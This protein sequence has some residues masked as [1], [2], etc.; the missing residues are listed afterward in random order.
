MRASLYCLIFSLFFL[1]SCSQQTDKSNSTPPINPYE[2]ALPHGSSPPAEGLSIEDQ[3]K[4]KTG[5]GKQVD[6]LSVE[7]LVWMLDSLGGQLNVLNFW[8][9][10]CKECPANNKTL[11]KAQMTLGD[12]SVF[13]QHINL[14][15][16]EMVSDV[17][18]Q[19]RAQGLINPCVLLQTQGNTQ[20][21]NAVQSN[22]DGSLPALVLINQDEGIR[23]FY[24]KIFSEDELLALFQPFTL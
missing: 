10:S 21:M 18:A 5:Y 13:I 7:Q 17:N 19:I 22:W 23:L 9:L 12:S 16:Q 3:K 24:Q 2:S 15:D 14:D 6:S 1:Q 8:S 11:E 20:W 4:L